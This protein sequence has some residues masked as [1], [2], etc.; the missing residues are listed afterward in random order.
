[1]CWMKPD[2]VRNRMLRIR[3][4]CPSLQIVKPKL[5]SHAERQ[6]LPTHTVYAHISGIVEGWGLGGMHS[7]CLNL[8]PPFFSI[9][10]PL[11]LPIEIGLL[12]CTARIPESEMTNRMHYIAQGR[13]SE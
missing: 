8:I 11:P 6:L 4:R 3:A 9:C 7:Y 2:S 10:S 5:H 1:M 12:V 13:D